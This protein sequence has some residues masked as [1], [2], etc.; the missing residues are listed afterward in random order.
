MTPGVP[1]APVAPTGP[2]TPCGP[3]T[4]PALIEVDKPLSAC[5]PALM[6]VQISVR[7][8]PKGMTIARR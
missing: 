8:A 4:I 3:A 7:L 6:A 2:W 5:T 1:A